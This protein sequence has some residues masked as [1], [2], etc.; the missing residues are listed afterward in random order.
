MVPDPAPTTPKPTVVP[1]PHSSQAVARRLVAEGRILVQDSGD[2]AAV[3]LFLRA[4]AADSLNTHAYWEL[5]ASYH[6]LRAWHDAVQAWQRL[7]ELAPQYPNLARRLPIVRMRRDRAST[8]APPVEEEPRKGTPI[9]I[10][11]VGDIQLGR[12]W[13]EDNPILPPDNAAHMFGRVAHWLRAADITFGN[14]ETVLA[15]SGD[16]TKCVVV[17]GRFPGVPVRMFGIGSAAT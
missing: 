15:D 12:S 5:G 8:P 7:S 16:S 14:L 17:G 4:L 9:R 11:A 2:R 13:P 1:T 6:R 10:A 3:Q